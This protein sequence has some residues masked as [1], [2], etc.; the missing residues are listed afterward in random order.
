M[1]FIRQMEEKLAKN[2]EKYENI[3]Q[4]AI[5]LNMQSFSECPYVKWITNDSKK[6]FTELMGWF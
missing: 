3:L 2:D 5:E 1:T 4:K 6:S